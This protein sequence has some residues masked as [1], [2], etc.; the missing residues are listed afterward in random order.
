MKLKGWGG[1]KMFKKRFIGIGLLFIFFCLIGAAQ[2]TSIT[3]TITDSDGI[4]WTNAKWRVLFVPNPNQPSQCIYQLNGQSICSNIYKGYLDQSGTSDITTGL[5]S[6][7]LLDNSLITPSGSKFIWTVQSNTS[8]PA[9]QYVPIVISGTSQNLSSFLSSNSTAPRFPAMGINSFG[10]SDLEISPAPLQG[11]FY[12]NVTSKVTRVWDGAEFFA[13]NNSNSGLYKNLEGYLFADQW[14]NPSNNGLAQALAQCQS[15]PYACQIVAPSL[16]AQTEQPNYEFWNYLNSEALQ[17]GNTQTFGMQELRFQNYGWLS[18]NPYTILPTSTNAYVGFNFKTFFGQNQNLTSYRSFNGSSITAVHTQGGYANT[19]YGGI[20]TSLTGLRISALR[21]TAEQ[22]SGLSLAATG[23]SPGDV[24]TASL[25]NNCNAGFIF[26]FD[27][28]CEYFSTAGGEE[29]WEYRG[30]VASVSGNTITVTPDSAGAGEIISGSQGDSKYVIDTSSGTS[31]STPT[32]IN[33]SGTTQLFGST[34]GYFTFF[35]YTTVPTSTAY[36]IISTAINPKATQTVNFSLTGGTL[37]TGLACVADQPTSANAAPDGMFELVTITSVVGSTAT[38]FFTKQHPAGT[39]IWQGG[40]CGSFLEIQADTIPAGT[41]WSTGQGSFTLIAPVRYVYPILGSPDG[42]H[43]YFYSASNYFSNQYGIGTQWSNA[44]NKATTI[45]HGAEVYSVAG[46]NEDLSDNKFTLGPNDGS[47]IAGVHIEEPHMYVQLIG[48]GGF[49]ITNYSPHGNWTGFSVNLNGFAQG[50]NTNSGYSLRNFVAS[51]LYK[52]LGGNLVLPDHAFN[53]DGAMLDCIRAGASDGA[54]PQVFMNLGTQN[55]AEQII[56][57][58]FA[59]SNSDGS[60]FHAN[61]YVGYSPDAGFTMG[62]GTWKLHGY[63]QST[64]GLTNTSINGLYGT[65]TNVSGPATTTVT[66][67]NYIFFV[68][69]TSG[70]V[71]LTLPAS[72]NGG[73]SYCFSKQGANS[74]TIDPNGHA[75][76]GSV[77][78][79]VIPAGMTWYGCIFQDSVNWYFP[80]LWVNGASSILPTNTQDDVV[81]LSNDGYH[82]HDAGFK[83]TQASASAVTGHAAC[84]KSLAPLI[85]GSCSTQPDATGACTCN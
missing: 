78:N 33:Q 53:C 42:T 66:T 69:T 43:L 15:L 16:Y 21:N 12:F 62:G 13:L 30:T 84:V 70:A 79:L 55:V 7:T 56:M 68:D 5:I 71:T 37:T 6:A 29:P 18:N 50:G 39:T 57:A 76:N 3:A 40:Y 44:T 54:G 67:N 14:Q 19:T 2:T 24:V 35:T 31:T 4:V 49:N 1:C 77:Q 17:Y 22:I 72:T 74:L 8:A 59:G 82:I 23:R 34:Y 10:Y 73:Q 48:V 38:A 60:V 65:V 64:L 45:Y 11:N 9:T 63:L 47:I 75:F 52:P 80:T 46:A 58:P 85:V 81:T 83:P 32:A 27:E 36:G 28:G 26:K 20:Q 61:D 25:V 51:S 41:S